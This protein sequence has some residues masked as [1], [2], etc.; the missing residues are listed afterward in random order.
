MIG[1]RH[2]PPQVLMIFDNALPAALAV[3]VVL[4]WLIGDPRWLWGRLKHPVVILGSLIDG[5]DRHVNHGGSA[6]R[7][8]AGFAVLA[9]IMVL[10]TVAG[11]LLASLGW[12]VE[13]IVIAI[14]LA[15]RDLHDQ[16]KNVATSLRRDGLEE[17]RR[18]VGHIVGRDT[19]QLDSHGISR[20][21]IESCAENFADGV[22][23]PLFWY[24]V[25]GLP[26]L[27]VCKAVNTLD[28]MIGHRDSRHHAFGQASARCDDL[29]NLLP[30]RLSAVVV[31]GASIFMTGADPRSSLQAAWRD[32]R[33]HRSPNAGWPEAAFA[34][35]LGIAIA[36]PRRYAGTLVNDAWMGDGRAA[37]TPDDIDAALRLYVRSCVIAASLCVLL[38]L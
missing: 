27:L 15:Q 13:A 9:A 18:M 24:V 38:I 33:Y 20:A 34:G 11:I 26:G 25:A 12:A 19:G 32:A 31:A 3:A 21:A 36:G 28:S 8:I 7:R 17:G 29:L 37:C 22:V 14:L 1:T 30:A 6:R 2:I 23:A 16:V 10:A 4:D 5:L 35:A